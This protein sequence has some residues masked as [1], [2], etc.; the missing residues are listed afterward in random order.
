MP[1]GLLGCQNAGLTKSL[2]VKMVK[3]SVAKVPVCPNVKKPTKVCKN[4]LLT[5]SLSANAQG[6][7]NVRQPNALRPMS[8]F[9]KT[10]VGQMVFDEKTPSQT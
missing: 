9:A 7:Q 8:M 1:V 2:F 5:Y 6:C 10:P 4:F 3:M